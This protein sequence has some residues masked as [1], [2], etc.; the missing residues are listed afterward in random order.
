[1][2]GF[3]FDFAYLVEFGILQETET[4]RE[5]ERERERER[6]RRRRRNE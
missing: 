1:V 6:R 2:K 5:R 4:T 3:E